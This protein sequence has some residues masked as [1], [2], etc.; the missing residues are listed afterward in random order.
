L[1]GYRFRDLTYTVSI[2]QG[3]GGYGHRT[4]SE[5]GKV[6]GSVV[7]AG[8][9]LI[10][11][12]HKIGVERNVNNKIEELYPNIKKALENHTGVIVIVQYQIWKIA[13]PDFNPPE[14]LSVMLGPAASN[15]P[16]AIRQWEQTSKL[17]QG[18]TDGKVFGPH[19]YLWFTRDL[20]NKEKLKKS[21]V[22]IL[23]E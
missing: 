18:P 7:D 6:V 13:D 4:V 10:K 2:P 1:P 20:T 11:F 5:R 19:K 16:S 23:G 14:L 3:D 21:E 9:S 12:A 22:S 8:S 17:V 15:L